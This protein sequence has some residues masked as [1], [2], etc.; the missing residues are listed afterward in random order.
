M[1]RPDGEERPGIT[2]RS[3]L[4]GGATLAV[5]GAAGAGW[6]TRQSIDYETIRLYSES[7]VF[8][9]PGS[10]TLVP[11]G[12]ARLVVPGTRVL[13]GIF[14]QERLVDEEAAWLGRSASWT[15][16]DEETGYPADLAQQA[17]LDIRSL[18]MP[19]GASVAAWSPKWRYTWPRDGSHVAAA[20]SAAEHHLEALAVLMFLQDVQSRDGW[21]E[22]RYLPD[23]L[24]IPDDRERQ[25]DGVGW[26]LWACGRLVGRRD[27]M[28]VRSDLETISPMMNRSL[29]LVLAS[30]DTADHLPPASPDYWEVR[31]TRLT[32]GVAAP[33]LAGLYGAVAAFGA[34]GDVRS[35][36]EALR[37]ADRLSTAIHRAFGPDGYPRYVGGDE[38]CTSVA[39]LLPPYVPGS[40]PEVFEAF[41]RAQTELLRPAGGLAPGAGWKRDGISWTPETAVFAMAAADSGREEYARSTLRW[42]AEHRTAVGSLP[43]KVL[44]DGSPAAVA[45][46]AWTAANVVLA[47]DALNG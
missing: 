4:I 47:V 12:R 22:A 32:L 26:V 10:R 13:S 24:G 15:F 3:V 43:E 16:S 44:H 41:D 2:R 27:P 33:L 29:A 38:R 31:E 46:L 6:A 42:L 25:L 28:L 30:I 21:F 1:T 40:P 9:G 20:L 45:P 23:G 8:D 19:N 37:G 14:E 39:F 36:D 34:L 7:V 17:L 35:R 11:A 18:L 5:L